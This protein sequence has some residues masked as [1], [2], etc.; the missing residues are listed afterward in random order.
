M[1]ASKQKYEGQ[2][3][4]LKESVAGLESLRRF[5]KGMWT[6]KYENMID[7]RDN[8]IVERKL[9]YDELK[10]EK[11]RE[12][13]EAHKMLDFTQT[14]LKLSAKQAFKWK[15]PVIEPNLEVQALNDKARLKDV[16]LKNKNQ[17]LLDALVRLDCSDKLLKDGLRKIEL[18]ESA[19]K[20]KN[21]ELLDARAHLNLFREV[22][23]DC[24]GVV[25]EEPSS[26]RVKTLRRVYSSSRKNARGAS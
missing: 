22:R 21:R 17:D 13:Q 25:E 23:S 7:Q 6:K 9:K 2:V 19:L 5:E 16:E 8:E 26:E 18:K 1:D 24:Q 15:R 11:K 3:K 12:L 20:A 10:Q 14:K 4:E